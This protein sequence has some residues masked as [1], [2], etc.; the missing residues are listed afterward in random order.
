M[1][2]QF[3]RESVIPARP[4]PRPWRGYLRFSVR[5]LVL[6]VLVIGVGLGWIVRSA[7]IQREAVAA[8]RNAGASVSYDWEWKDGK[9]I[10]GGELRAPRWLVDRM[11]VDYFGHVTA[12]SLPRATDAGIVQVARLT[13]LQQ[14]IMHPS[15]MD[16]VGVISFF[17]VNRPRVTSAGLVHLKGLTDLLRLDVEGTGISDP[18][19][20]ELTGLSK[21]SDLDLSFT[22]VT[23]AGLKHLLGLTKLCDL[24]L[25]GTGVTEAGMKELK[26]ALPRLSITR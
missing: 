20:A 16:D 11:G 9:D 24:E 5:G 12:V 23:D 13:Q 10:P 26:A 18:G 1:G 17:D 4:L 22:D 21:L 2:P 7:A 6:L 3:R 14:L 19:L 15:S 8:I 25:D